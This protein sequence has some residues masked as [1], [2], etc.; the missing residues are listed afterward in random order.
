MG[1]GAR[2]KEQ[3]KAEAAADMKSNVAESGSCLYLECMSV[4]N[5]DALVISQEKESRY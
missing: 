3:D 5:N 2:S 1:Q 4:H